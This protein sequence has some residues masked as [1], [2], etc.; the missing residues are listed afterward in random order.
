MRPLELGPELTV[1]PLTLDP[2][3]V[4]DALDSTRFGT[5]FHANECLSARVMFSQSFQGDI[6]DSLL[7]LRR[8]PVERKRVVARLYHPFIRPSLMT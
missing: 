3:A 4:D 6:L 1:H 7:K 2:L 8:M 5:A